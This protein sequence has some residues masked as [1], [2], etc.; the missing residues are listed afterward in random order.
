[1][2]PTREEVI[3]K[4]MEQI[5]QERIRFLIYYGNLQGEDIDLLVVLQ[6][7]DSDPQE[8]QPSE[9][10]IFEIREDEF[11]SRLILMDPIV[12][13]PVITGRIILGN[14]VEFQSIRDEFLLSFPSQEIINSLRQR[15]VEELGNAFTF[16]NKYRKSKDVND[17]F[18]ALINLSFACSYYEFADYY[19]QNPEFHPISF[20]HL[21]REN[22]REL[23][24][25]IM[26]VLKGVKKGE[27][28]HINQIAN[29]FKKTENLLRGD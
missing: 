15:A 3:Q 8:Y 18:F 10:D 29:L 21:L 22:N 25:E 5:Y 24:H 16:L 6:N 26:S 13:E 23:L 28:F 20:A 9:F 1:M 2:K 7:W 19:Q 14:E 4:I 11:R 17:L 12:A 27:E